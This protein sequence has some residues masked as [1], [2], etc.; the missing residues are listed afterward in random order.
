VSRS[1]RDEEVSR[2]KQRDESVIPITAENAV[3]VVVVVAGGWYSWRC[4]GDGRNKVS[5]F[6]VQVEF[7]S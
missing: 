4:G 6:W 1:G 2:N 5:T 7:E 3:A